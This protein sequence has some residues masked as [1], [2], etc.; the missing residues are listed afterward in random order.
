MVDIETQEKAIKNREFYFSMLKTKVFVNKGDENLS[1]GNG[2]KVEVVCPFCLETRFI[3]F[4][5]A[6]RVG[7]TLHSHCSRII[8][9]HSP[10]IGTKIGRL[11][12]VNFGPIIQRKKQR[13]TT[14]LVECECGVEKVCR[15][16]VLKSGDALSCGCYN[17][18]LTAQRRGQLSHFWNPNL[19]EEE[20]RGRRD[21]DVKKWATQVKRRDDFTCQVCGS[22]E[23]LVAHHL[24]SYKSDKENRYNVEN[25]ITLCRECHT[26]FHCNFM[27]D[28]RQPCNEDD[29]EQYLLQV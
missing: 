4:T 28:Y 6:N 11:F 5:D 15:T 1:P 22:E 7:N 26:D 13:D 23:K 9:T 29:F 20:R 17:R 24:N 27:G 12:I 2:K 8:R 19:T 25:G 10:L 18:E 21:G 16:N 3:C 14:F